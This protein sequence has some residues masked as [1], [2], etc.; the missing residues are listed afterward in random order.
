MEGESRVEWRRGHSEEGDMAR[1]PLHSLCFMALFLDRLE[2]REKV[3]NLKIKNTLN[4]NTK[5][6]KI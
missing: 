6:L 5:N 3:E 1:S 2:N 4:K